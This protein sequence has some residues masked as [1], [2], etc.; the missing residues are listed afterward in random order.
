MNKKKFLN[1]NLYK[2]KKTRFSVKRSIKIFKT[3]VIIILNPF[4]PSMSIFN[5]WL[6]V[7]IYIYLGFYFALNQNLN[8]QKFHGN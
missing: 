4:V 3:S 2:F 6:S 7:I 1:L 5:N 8:D